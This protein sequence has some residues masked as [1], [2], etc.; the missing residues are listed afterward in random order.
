[1]GYSDDI[2]FSLPVEKYDEKRKSLEQNAVGS[3][4]LGWITK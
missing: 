3:V 2:N 1:M 4:Q